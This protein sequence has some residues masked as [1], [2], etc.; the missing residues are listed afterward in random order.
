MTTTM[1]QVDPVVEPVAAIFRS[2]HM[3]GHEIEVWTGRTDDFREQTEQW[4]MDAD[5]WP[6]GLRMRPVGDFRHAHE[7]KGEWLAER[8]PELVF[9]DRSSM[10]KWW[11]EQGIVG[12]DVADNDY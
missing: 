1:A 11:R 9:E 12:C 6:N 4:L 8:R 3:V 7:V 2:L 10:V 5:L